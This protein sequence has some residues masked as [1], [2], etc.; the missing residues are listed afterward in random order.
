VNHLDRMIEEMRFRERLSDELQVFHTRAMEA[1]YGKE[2]IIEALGRAVL[3]AFPDWAA[4]DVG[5]RLNEPLEWRH[6]WIAE[7]SWSP[8]FFG[9][10]TK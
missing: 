3:I 5:Y 1:S 8:G 9:R 4:D 2:V 7:G 10:E 6:G